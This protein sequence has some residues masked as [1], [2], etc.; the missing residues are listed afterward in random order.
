[1]TKRV[2]KLISDS[3]RSMATD[4]VAKATEVLQ[5]ISGRLIEEILTSYPDDR[6]LSTKILD[7]PE[8]FQNTFMLA[9]E[10]KIKVDG[11]NIRSCHN[12][13]DPKSNSVVHLFIHGLGGNI[14]QFEPLFRL[15]DLK[16]RLFFAIDLPGFGKSDELEEYPMSKVVRIIRS[17]LHTVTDSHELVI[18][19]HS[20]GCHLAIHFYTQFQKHETINNLI[21][22]APA[23]P[24]LPQL[25]YLSTRVLLFLLFK[26]PF[27]F[28]FYRAWFDQSKGLQSSGIK[29]F[30][31]KGA[32][33]QRLS[34]FHNNVQIK[35]RSVVG[36]LRGWEPIDWTH[37]KLTSKIEVIA[38]DKDP[39][40]P[41]E[42]VEKFYTMLGVTPQKKFYV[43]KD[44]S[45]NIC[46]DQPVE[47]VDT[48][49]KIISSQ[50]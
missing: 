15:L 3:K 22:F 29:Q 40:T 34:Q 8:D 43:L 1:M 9:H 19:G 11:L 42:V 36:Y 25:N 39:I 26:M 16:G 30:F 35:S 27:F 44:C 10:H 20:M 47:A 24:N 45:H 49:N 46:F 7:H 2:G 18:V 33:Y 13:Q 38:G 4:I 21:L 6:S 5:P 32:T 14:W 31:Y 48:F 12:I 28:D 37:L 23:S 41:L 17:S 50:D